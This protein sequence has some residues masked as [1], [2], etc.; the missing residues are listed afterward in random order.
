MDAT[1]PPLAAPAAAPASEAAATGMRALLR[2]LVQAKASDLHVSAA[3]TP[4]FRL[5]GEMTPVP[6]CRALS[7]AE[8]EHL[9][10]SIAPA[11]ARE[12]FERRHDTDFAYEIEGL[13]A[14]A[15]TSSWTA[16]ASAAVFRVIPSNILTA[17]IDGPVGRDPRAVQAAQGA[18]AGHRSDRLGQV[19]H[20]VRAGRL[21]QPHTAPITSSRSRTR[22]SSCTRTRSASSTSARSAN[23]TDSFKDALRAALR[24][25]PDIVL[26]GEMRDLE[27]IAI[28]IETAETGHLV[29]GTLHTS[30]A[31]RHRGPHHRPVPGRAAGADP[32]DAGRRR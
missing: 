24:E 30:T 20:V 10:L 25:D 8:T 15:A 2:A 14:S 22:S 23:H 18:G 16:R 27:T 32:H 13:A 21:H 4:T 3:M 9:L 6:G 5:D 1:S 11:R 31:H 12:E 17:E 7:G 19:D 29:F 26:V 28:A